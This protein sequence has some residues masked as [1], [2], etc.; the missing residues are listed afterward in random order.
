MA[1]AYL[2]ARIR[3]HDKDGFETFKQMS[4]PLIS[5]YGG[6]LLARNPDVD[7]LEGN[8]QGLVV[9]LEFD[10]MDEARRFYFSDGYTA[11]KLVRSRR[12]KLILSLLRAFRRRP[13]R[14]ADLARAAFKILDLQTAIVHASA[15]QWSVTGC[16]SAGRRADLG[17]QGT[18]Q[19][20][21]VSSLV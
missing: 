19:S 7:I 4:T 12:L 21:W 13:V 8:Q 14:L 20:A 9:L 1:K 6:R 5:E 3:V 11:A 16:D 18:G 17:Q 2:I 15:P 10:S